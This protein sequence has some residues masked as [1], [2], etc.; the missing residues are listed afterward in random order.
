MK[1]Y[2]KIFAGFWAATF[3]M[4]SLALLAGYLAG[5]GPRQPP[6]P[7]PQLIKQIKNIVHREGVAGLQVW[8][9][10]QEFLERDSV[11]IV[12]ARQKAIYP[13]E[14][15]QAMREIFATEKRAH[16]HRRF[17]GV[18][19]RRPLMG[20]AG[21][22][23]QMIVRLPPPWLQQ[24]RQRP[25]L[26]YGTAFLV[27]GLACY[28][29]T[30]LLTR[31]IKSL[32]DTVRQLADGQLGARVAWAAG[33]T[34][35]DDIQRLGQDVNLMANRLQ[36]LLT[37]QEQLIK[38]MSHELRSPLARM[39]VLLELLRQLD[40][41]SCADEMDRMEREIGRLDS[42]IS[43]LLL[44]PRLEQDAQLA[45]QTIDMAALLS[46][47]VDDCQQQAATARV[48]FA[49]HV[50]DGEY[51]VEGRASLLRSA[52]ENILLNALRF[53]PPDSLLELSLGLLGELVQVQV[54]DSG[55]GLE[56]AELERIFEPFYRVSSARE[57]D[58]GGVGLGL[59]IARRV[60]LAHGGKVWA[61]NAN[62]GLRVTI[63]LPRSTG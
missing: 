7:A 34:G 1:L 25:L 42:I 19:I 40:T 58:S 16:P 24:F 6:P 17:A 18:Y 35:G 36:G 31:R 38:G 46:T 52:C 22:R 54:R 28:L 63:Q 33:T 29:L 45:D 12:D 51:L 53:A 30:L 44:L 5:G 3:L 27:S 62:P 13:P 61:Q 48:R 47:L 20:P 2:W 55:S 11:Y 59:A 39:Q 26:R 10:Q 32:G 14:I 56:V 49:L 41:G 21:E 8:L 4:V 15:P 60:V 9:E 57:R 37:G 50:E 43:D 23:W